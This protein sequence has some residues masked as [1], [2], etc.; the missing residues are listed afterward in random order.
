MDVGKEAHLSANQFAQWNHNT[1]PL[2]AIHLFGWKNDQFIEYPNNDSPAY[3]QHV[4]IPYYLTMSRDH[5]VP[6]KMVDYG[7]AQGYIYAGVYEKAQS[8]IHTALK[9]KGYPD[10]TQFIALQKQIHN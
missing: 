10:N 7:L 4:V 9:L 6:I 8:V 2:Y 1:G 3:Y 5:S